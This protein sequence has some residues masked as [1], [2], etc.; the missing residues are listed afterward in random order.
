MIGDHPDVVLLSDTML[1]SLLHAFDDSSSPM[2]SITS[3]YSLHQKYSF[4]PRFNLKMP[5]ETES[6]LRVNADA[7]VET[8]QTILKP[9]WIDG[10]A[11]EGPYVSQ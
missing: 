7:Y 2:T 11:N 6:G 9:P 1:F 8:L 4:C 10:V 5:S 3:L